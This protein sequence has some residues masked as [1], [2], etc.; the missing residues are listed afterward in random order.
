VTAAPAQRGIGSIYGTSRV[1]PFDR[2]FRYPA[3]FS[4][5]ALRLAADAAGAG[6][7]AIVVDPFLGSAAT[8]A[9]LP[10]QHVVGIEAHPLIADLAATKL[11]A[12]P[13]PGEALREAAKR[14]VH[15]AED[16][17]SDGASEHPLVQRCFEPGAL[18]CLARLR[19]AIAA[20]R[21]D[22]WRRHLRWALLGTLRDVASVKVGWPYQR[23][24]VDRDAPYRDPA[25]RFLARAG[26]IAEDLELALG[27]RPSGRVVRGDARSRSSWRRAAKGG[28]FDACIT[29]PPYLNNFDYAD[30]T[31]LELYF[32]G[33]VSSWAE[34]CRLVREDMVVATTQQSA[35]RRGRRASAHLRAYPGVAPEIEGLT[36]KL[37]AER[38]LRTRGKE[39]DQVLPTYFADMT[40]VLGHLHQHMTP[41]ARAAWVVG[42]SAPYGVYV[43]TPAIIVRLASAIGFKTEHDVTVRSRGLRWQTNGS[44]HQVPLSER[45]VT[46]RRV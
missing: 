39:Y 25:G 38:A 36:K 6:S 34:M 1:R 46:F 20:R 13:G 33:T 18:E 14:L 9:G 40:R 23:P 7:G 10:G 21:R 26:M 30:A 17:S 27:K 22:R 43:D 19:D 37:A 45:L 42:D 5:E 16:R 24:A 4:P 3:G 2:W 44:R 31:R 11:A 12:P 41:G 32:L 15:I 28:A 35:R 29:S 8:A